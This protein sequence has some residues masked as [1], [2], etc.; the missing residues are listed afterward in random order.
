[1]KIDIDTFLILSLPVFAGIVLIFL[2]EEAIF[3]T[4]ILTL[5]IMT[6]LG[7]IHSKKEIYGFSGLIILSIPS[8]VLLSYTLI[9]A[10]PSVYICLTKKTPAI[11]PYFYTVCGFYLLLA[12]GYRLGDRL[13]RIDHRKVQEIQKQP[14]REDMSDPLV[15][16]LLWFLLV[17]G[18]AIYAIY[19]TQLKKIPIVELL[20]QEADAAT[21][22]LLREESFKLL[23]VP[24]ILKYLVQWER[25][26]LM[27]FGMIASLFLYV[28]YDRKKYLIFFWA[29]FFVGLTFNSLTIEKSP[30]ATIFMAL[31]A[32]FYLRKKKF[33]FK[34][35]FFSVIVVFIIPIVI[36]YLKFKAEHEKIADFIVQSLFERIFLIPTQMIYEHFVIFPDKV[37]FL[38]GRSSQLFSWMHTS[39]SVNLPQ[40]V[41]TI[42]YKNPHT[43]VYLN[44][45][46]LANFWADFGTVGIVLSTVAVGLIL[47]WITY[48]LLSATEYQKSLLFIVITTIT[49]PHFTIQFLSANF[50]ILFF[51]GGL[52]LVIFLLVAVRQLKYYLDT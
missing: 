41:A 11:Y 20:T 36:I 51:T 27:P 16:E 44:A 31:M 48:K 34:Y 5:S 43:V 17:T 32:F 29:F 28:V 9:I 42:Y 23:K 13:W 22:S 19:L 35:A 47:H 1:M 10:L 12:L 33:S 15:A 50:T 40:L 46:Y 21:F 18:I 14:F 4:T 37:D 39:P 2:P 30:T 8:L 26:L 52:L 25:F 45:M 38:L 7:I 6:Y 49:M 24:A 3:F